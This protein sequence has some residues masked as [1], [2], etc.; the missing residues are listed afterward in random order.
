MNIV[1]RKVADK[2][3]YEKERL[4]MHVESD[5]DIGRYALLESTYVGEGEVS[6]K[7]RNTLWLPDTSV[8]AGEL[9]VVYTKKGKNKSR[10]NTDKSKSHF[11]Y[12]G[13]GESIW[14]RENA[15]AVIFEVADWAMKKV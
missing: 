13:L 6:G 5:G 7:I 8:E 9:V 4:I 12:W 3:N 15:C 10:E 1:I 14:S 2:G 11:I